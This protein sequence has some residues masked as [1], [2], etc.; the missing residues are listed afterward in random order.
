MTSPLVRAD[1]DNPPRFARHGELPP[2]LSAQELVDW[3]AL[4]RVHAGGVVRSQGD[5]LDGAA[6][7]PRSLI[8]EVL[9]DVLVRVGLLSIGEPDPLGLETVSLTEAGQ[10]RYDELCRFKRQREEPAALTP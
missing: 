10:A 2:M 1:V 7:M 4:S 3:M 9:F 6:P 5:Y 8:P